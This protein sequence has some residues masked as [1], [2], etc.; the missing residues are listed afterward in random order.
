MENKEAEVQRQA[1]QAFPVQ[2]PASRWRVRGKMAGNVKM[3]S[4]KEFSDK[5]LINTCDAT[6]YL[7]QKFYR[8][9]KRLFVLIKGKESLTKVLIKFG[10]RFLTRFKMRKA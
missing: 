8:K 6:L 9:L 1:Y 10:L 4:W 3:L 2:R 5:V 7:Y